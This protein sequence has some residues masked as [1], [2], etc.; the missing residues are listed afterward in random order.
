MNGAI[1]VLLGNGDGT[2]QPAVTYDSGGHFAFSV[3]VADVNGD[4]KPDIVV[5]ND[6]SPTGSVSVL[7][8]NGDGTFQPAVS[9]ATG[10][11]FT[12]SIAVADLNGDGKP[13][14]VVANQCVAGNCANNGAGV[15]LGNGDGTF[16]PAVNY[17]SG[18]APASVAVSDLNGDGKPDIVVVNEGGPV[19][20]LLGNGDGTFQGAMSYGLPGQ[21]PAFVVVADLN[22]DGKQDLV[23]AGGGTSNSSCNAAVTAGVLLGNGDGTFQSAD[24]YCLDRGNGTSVAVA[25]LNGDGKV[26]LV[27]ADGNNYFISVLLANGTASTTTVLSSSNPSIVGQPLTFTIEAL[28]LFSGIPTGTVT[29]KKNA[30]TLK[31]LVLSNGQASYTTSSLVLGSWNFTAI[32]GGDGNFTGSTS[33]VLK[34][35]IEKA[36]TTTVVTSSPNPVMVGQSVTF[37]ATVSSPVGPPPNG[38]MVIFKDGTTTIGTG[39]L[40]AGNAS[41]TTSSLP[42]G[43]QTINAIYLADSKF[44]GS[45]ASIVEVVNGYATTTTVSSNNNPSIYGQSVMFTATV[46]SGMGGTPTGTVTFKNGSSLLGQAPLSGGMAS[47]STSTLTA[48]TH[49]IT[50]VYNGDLTH[51]SSTSPP[52]SQVVNKAS[53]ILSLGSSQNPSMMG[54]AVTFAATVTSTTSGTPTGNVTFKD[55]SA[56]LGTMALSGGAASLTTSTLSLGNHTIM[57]TYKGS[58]N[59]NGSS[60]T[61]V[62]VVN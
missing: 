8:G 11:Y 62:Q 26:D 6:S 23:V 12:L 45:S 52:L 32:Y 18:P 33:T 9:Y 1:G 61:L 60:A 10:A 17:D 7:L 51:G 53:T 2:F 21:S 35:V 37:S 19:D 39:A 14:L 13:D 4:G 44:A 58:A 56:T 49:T 54:Q 57:A 29:L 24:S 41:F 59:F 34:Q 30:S 40:S 15:L 5:A 16:Q 22:G 38:E 3:A 42:A 31:T 46:T 20:V 43:S 55:G 36:P 27:T 50:A 47:L 25:D 48:S 28:P